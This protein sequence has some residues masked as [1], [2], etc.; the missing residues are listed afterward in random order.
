MIQT[1]VLADALAEAV[2]SANIQP[3]LRRSF[4]EGR[5]SLFLRIN[6]EFNRVLR[7]PKLFHCSRRV[8]SIIER[9]DL[10][11]ASN[12]MRVLIKLTASY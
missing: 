6:R 12:V 2:I 7:D 3:L 1:A 11:C 4:G 5:F 10:G 9:I 8:V